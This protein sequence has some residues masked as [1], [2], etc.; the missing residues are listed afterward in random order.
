MKG[1]KIIFATLALMLSAC[2]PQGFESDILPV[3]PN[4]TEPTKNTNDSTSPT[5]DEASS[6]ESMKSSD[7]TYNS[8]VYIDKSDWSLVLRIPMGFN[9]FIDATQIPLPQIKGATVTTEVDSNLNSSLIVRVPLKYVLHG[10]SQLEK[11]TQLPNGDAL[12]KMPAGESASLGL[13]ISAKKSVKVNIYI[14]VEA[15]GVFVETPF[16]YPFPAYLSLPLKNEAQTQIL[17]WFTLVPRKNSSNS[18][19]FLS[20]KLPSEVSV[21]LNK[22]L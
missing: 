18:G 1:F 16:D 19:F 11:A 8:Q 12:P 2:A 22:Y 5:A 3:S 10:V 6:I 20:F 13:T 9:P 21:I 17:G 4:T 14:A 7:Q 15:V